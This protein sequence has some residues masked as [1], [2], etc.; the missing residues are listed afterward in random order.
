MIAEKAAAEEQW[1]KVCRALEQADTRFV[2]A[3][4][5]WRGRSHQTFFNN[6]AGMKNQRERLRVREWR[7]FLAN[8]GLGEVQGQRF[9]WAVPVRFVQ[10]AARSIVSETLA[11]NSVR[12]RK[13]TS[14]PARPP[15]RS[16]PRLL[17]F[18]VPLR[19]GLVGYVNIP[20]G[21]THS[22]VQGFA[23][24]MELLRSSAAGEEG[25][26]PIETVRC[27]VYTRSAKLDKDEIRRQRD[28]C[29]RLVQDQADRGWAWVPRY[30]DD[31][32]HSGTTLWRP[33]LWN[34]IR[35]ARRGRFE[36]VVVE[37]L[38][39]LTRSA[40]DS[41]RVLQALSLAGVRVAIANQLEEDE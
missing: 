39:R 33:A 21:F 23:S 4:A 26:R 41:A 11:R 9:V 32:G 3:L 16:R 25:A 22:D 7:E 1:L 10:K 35:D 8:T 27:A 37:Y 38:S 30:Y 28:A 29:N 2:S 24:W 12:A 13:P 17:E 31:A 19:N 15:L 40:T 14:A 5:T 20:E 36:C 6:L 18:P 34:L